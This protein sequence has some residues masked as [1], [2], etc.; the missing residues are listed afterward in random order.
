MG[1]NSRII[2]AGAI[3]DLVFVVVGSIVVL[4]RPSKMTWAFFFFC[5]AVEP[6][7]MIGWYYLPAW[8]VYGVGVTVGFLQAF[9]F[10]AF[11]VFCARVPGDRAVGRWRYLELDCCSHRFHKLAGV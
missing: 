2:F 11:L 8:V 7:L 6:G 3:V 1:S 9:G 10:A 4:L 5:L